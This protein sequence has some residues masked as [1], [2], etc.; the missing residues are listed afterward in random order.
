VWTKD[1]LSQLKIEKSIKDTILYE[2]N[3]KSSK[4]VLQI[5][6]NSDS[7]ISGFQIFK[8]YIE[9]DSLIPTNQATYFLFSRDQIIPNP[10][11]DEQAILRPGSKVVLMFPVESDKIPD[12]VI[13]EVMF[14]N[15]KN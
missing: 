7:L 9:N 12:P 4:L 10:S 15:K 5:T 8:N 3:E 6:N 1:F 11:S 14:A 2:G 13:G